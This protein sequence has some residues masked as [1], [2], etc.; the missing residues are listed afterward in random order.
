MEHRVPWLPWITYPFS[1][2]VL[3]KTGA[4]IQKGAE[5]IETHKWMYKWTS[6]S[7]SV[8][9]VTVLPANASS[10]AWT[11]EA[12]P[13]T[14]DNLSFLML[15]FFFFS[16]STDLLCTKDNLSTSFCQT[17]KT[18]KKCSVPTVRA[19]CCLTCSQTHVVHTRRPRKPQLLQNPKAF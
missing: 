18:M 4:N 16:P 10:I 9:H 17:L 12:Y 2:M 14:K 8:K 6:P 13:L 5:L 15:F 3:L 11:L 7:T 19:Q 1:R